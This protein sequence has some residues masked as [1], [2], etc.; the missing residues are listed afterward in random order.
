[1]AIGALAAITLPAAL[2]ASRIR[3]IPSGLRK[4]TTHST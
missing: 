1:V 4:D 2:T 3:L